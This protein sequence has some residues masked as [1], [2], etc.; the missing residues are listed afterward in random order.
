MKSSSKSNHSAFI[1]SDYR[2]A[3][4]GVATLMIVFFHLTFRIEHNALW[5]FSTHAM[6]GVEMFFLLS[7]MGLCWSMSRNGNLF[8]FYLKRMIRIFPTY[9]IV[10]LSCL[11]ITGTFSWK[12]FLL[13]WS[14]VGY[15][16]GDNYY[17]WYVPNQMMLYLLFP[18][19]YFCINRWRLSSFIMLVIGSV[20]LCLM[21]KNIDFMVLC[22]YPVFVTGIFLGTAMLKKSLL[23]ALVRASVI[24]FLIAFALSF[25]LHLFFTNQ[26][27]I[28]NGWLFKPQMLMVV[29]LCVLL[30]KALAKCNFCCKILKLI[31]AMS[32]EVYLLH[33]RFIDLAEY[34][35]ARCGGGRQVCI[36]ITTSL[37]LIFR[38]LRLA[39]RD[40]KTIVSIVG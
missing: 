37:R 18:L 33:N 35:S 8:H 13:E 29:G 10:I 24:L 1:L 2:T 38:G 7:G 26:Q 9:G 11:L 28:D 17:D 25:C 23:P 40:G 36:R 34:I 20:A 22:R 16:M 32:L 21:N 31:G 15:W 5:Y 39:Y 14:T 3:L 19:L 6:I 27:L 30:S 12:V 4:M